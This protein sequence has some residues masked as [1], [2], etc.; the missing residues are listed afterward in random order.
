MPLRRCDEERT[1]R[2]GPHIVDVADDP[3]R[4]KRRYA[5][6]LGAHVARQYGTGRIGLALDGDSR[7]IGW[8]RR[9]GEACGYAEAEDERAEGT[10]GQTHCGHV[11][12]PP[13]CHTT[14]HVS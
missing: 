1:E 4:R 14:P 2:I 3:V 10:G 8:R 7:V 11:S 13:Y 5:V 12:R 9:L 6:R